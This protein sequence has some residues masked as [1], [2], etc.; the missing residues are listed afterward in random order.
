MNI[1]VLIKN[2]F[3][4]SAE[5]IK[6]SQVV[7]NG[8]SERE[9][10]L[11]TDEELDSFFRTYL[12]MNS[13]IPV[14]SEES[15]GVNSPLTGKCW[16]VDPLDGSLNFFRGI[17]FYSSS[18][19]L[20][21][22]GIPIAGGIYDYV[23]NEFY[24]GEVGVGAFLNGKLIERSNSLIKSGIKATGIP[25]FSNVNISLKMFETS[26]NEYK[27]LRWLGCASLS[28]AYVASGKIDCYE[29]IGIKIWDVAAGMAIAIAAGAK[30]HSSFNSDGSLNLLVKIEN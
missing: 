29:E 26:L 6:K 14:F 10:K 9:I 16:I 5:I 1:E 21:N 25:S 3:E 17:P 23:H 22:D 20:W 27:K 28:L 4:Q 2:A 24:Y 11:S 30:V 12:E 7:S 19:G 15:G 18:I 8:F 13:G